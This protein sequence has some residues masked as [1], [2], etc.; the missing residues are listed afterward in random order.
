MA[1]VTPL[2]SLS[3]GRLVGSTTATQALY[4]PRDQALSIMSNP[5]AIFFDLGDTLA[6]FGT[7][8]ALA[9]CGRCRFHRG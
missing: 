2:L 1:A 5:I 6:Q 7:D 4:A 8:G 3:F 9:P